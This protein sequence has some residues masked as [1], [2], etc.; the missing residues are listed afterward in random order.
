MKVMGELRRQSEVSEATHW[1]LPIAG[2][3]SCSNSQRDRG[4]RRWNQ[5]LG[6][7]ERDGTMVGMEPCLRCYTKQREKG[8]MP[9]FSHFSSSKLQSL[10]SQWSILTRN[11]LSKSLGNAL[12]RCQGAAIH[13]GMEEGQ[14]INLK[15]NRQM[16]ST[17][18]VMV[19]F[20][21]TVGMAWDRITGQIVY[22]FCS[23]LFL[24]SRA[25]PP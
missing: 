24:T 19:I 1:S 21:G 10:S 15:T 2:N 8:E 3:C 16:T 5:G 17:V 13:S 6:I 11:Q 25:L 23:S 9:W 7:L 20:W 12:G 4:R 22:C 18:T 14:G